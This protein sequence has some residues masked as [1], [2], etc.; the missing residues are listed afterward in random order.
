MKML[1]NSVLCTVKRCFQRSFLRCYSAQTTKSLVHLDQRTLLQ[2]AGNEV[3]DFLQGLITNDMKH[4]EEGAMSIYS[5]FLNIKGRVLYDTI[6]YKAQEEGVFYVEC[7][8]SVV[9][10][11]SKHLKIYKLRRKVDIQSMEDS[12]K[13]WAVYDTNVLS[14]HDDDQENKSKLEGKMF[15][16]GMNDN[17]AIKLVENMSIY[18]DPRLSELG[19]RILTESNVTS[20]DIIKC[21]EP[22]ITTQEKV[23]NYRAFRYRLGVGEGV[24][25]LSSGVAFPL[26]AN[27]DYLHGVSF[28]KGC[29]IGQELTART[30]H[31]GVIRKR[32]MP[33][34]FNRV[35][36]KLL[37]YDEKITNEAA[38]VVGKIRGHEGMFGLGLVRIAEAS[39]SKTLTVRDRTVQIVKPRWWPQEAQKVEASL[40]TSKN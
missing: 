17:K 13:V 9:G 30:H 27:C 32:L 3:P 8:S 7:D 25:D 5:V 2:L 18:S 36:D 21:L 26:E 35:S 10:N 24:Q 15:P 6:I 29:Y 37:E 38:K 16:C 4:L 40:K 22:N 1:K 19:L 28:H 34:I 11:L 12:M 31:T 39:A 33:L 20:N 23:S 14:E